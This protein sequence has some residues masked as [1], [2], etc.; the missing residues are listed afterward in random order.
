MAGLAERLESIVHDRQ[1]LVEQGRLRLSDP[2]QNATG[3]VSNMVAG[4]L[5]LLA[6]AA[7][8]LDR[9]VGRFRSLLRES[10]MSRG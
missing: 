4:H 8:V 6:V 2:R 1:A 9:D 5:R 7:Y 3:T 10:M